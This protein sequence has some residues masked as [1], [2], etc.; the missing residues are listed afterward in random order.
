MSPFASAPETCGA[1]TISAEELE[2]LKSF[3]YRNL[4]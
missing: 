2:E 1:V 3:T 4:Q